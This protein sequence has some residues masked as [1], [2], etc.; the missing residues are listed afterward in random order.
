M[1]WPMTGHLIVEWWTYGDGHHKTTVATAD[2]ADEL[3]VSVDDDPSAGAVLIEFYEDGGRSM[4]VGAGR[5]RPVLNYQEPLDPP[6]FAS[7]G[8]DESGEDTDFSYGGHFSEFRS[9]NLVDKAAA[10]RAL[11][12]FVE[13]RRRP[14]KIRWE[15]L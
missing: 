10:R 14:S 9:I 7:L 13:T 12:E 15:Q 5:T 11:R 1:I 8:D 6:Y 3:F 4:T 2:D